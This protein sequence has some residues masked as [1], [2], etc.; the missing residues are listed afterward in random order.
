VLVACGC[1][2]LIDPWRDDLPRA[3]E[4]RTASVAGVQMG[5]EPVPQPSLDLKPTRLEPED[6]TVSHWPLYWEDPFVDKGSEDGQQAWTWEDY[7]AM[8]YGLGRNLLN[9]MGFP[10]SVVVTPP[11]TV[12]GSDGE[13]SRQALGYDH[14]ATRHPGVVPPRDHLEI[15][16]EYQEG[17]LPDE[18]EWLDVDPMP[19][20][21]SEDEAEPQ[22][23]PE[24]EIEPEPQ[25]ADALDPMLPA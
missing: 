11:W 14:D 19:D 16:T 18:A 5:A 2:Q 22:A 10:I 4:V 21:A 7:F 17:P 3:E 6:G 20:D 12:M 13:L 15:G 8:P 25:N 1:S 24:H 9:T 23:E